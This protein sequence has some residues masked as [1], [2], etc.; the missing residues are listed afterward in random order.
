MF[1]AAEFGTQGGFSGMNVLLQAA[2][3]PG[4]AQDQQDSPG[5]TP[6]Q[7]VGPDA[8][9]NQQTPGQV[10]GVHAFPDGPDVATLDKDRLVEAR[11]ISQNNQPTNK[12]LTGWQPQN[13]K[14]RKQELW[15]AI[16]ERDHKQKPKN[17]S[18]EDMVK[19]LMKPQE[20]P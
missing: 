8:A 9:S 17:W 15:Q 7:G 12:K 3:S 20:S 14:P 2:E 1:G 11:K 16:L 5:S 4:D 13:T 19:Y 6:N 10:A 18:I